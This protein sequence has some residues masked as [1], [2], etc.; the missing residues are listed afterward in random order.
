MPGPT[1]WFGHGS[2]ESP[3]GTD[4]IRP[5]P[6]APTKTEFVGTLEF[7]FG[8]LEYLKGTGDSK[9]VAFGI[10][11]KWFDTK[12]EA[13]AHLPELLDQR[14]PRWDDRE[15]II[16]LRSP[17]DSIPSTEQD[18][19]YYLGDLTID[20]EDG[21]TIASRWAKLWLPAADDGSGSSGDGGAGSGNQQRFLLEAPSDTQSG[22]AS[23]GQAPT[24]T[25]GALKALIAELSGDGSKEYDRCVQLTYEFKRRDRDHYIPKGRD[26]YP[27]YPDHDFSSGLAAKSVVHK[28]AR[29]RG[30]PPNTREELWLDGG[31]SALFEVEFGPPTL[32]DSS[33]DGVNDITMYDRS[34]VSARPLPA[35][36]YK[37]H[38]NNRLWFFLVCDGYVQR[39]EW[40]VTV[41]APAG[42]LH[43][44]F[45]DPVT[46]G[47]AVLAD[48]TNGVL[49][50]TS[51]TDANS[52]SATIQRI[53]W[54][55]NAGSTDGAGTVTLTLSPHTGL[56]NHVLDFIA[57][58]SKVTLSLDVDEATVDIA[59][60]TL[61][62]P[63]TNQPW[64]S[65][66]KLM[67]RIHNDPV[68]PV[69]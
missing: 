51:F 12:E 58:D 1:R 57:L 48:G 38:F 23:Q 45:F 14:D 5:H 31:D 26:R 10:S 69:P 25:L 13:K 47:S 56:A 59:S 21:Y 20:G 29:G 52:T 64:K 17:V 53:A 50:P 6:D 33:G 18:G 42:T 3:T 37:F 67:L 27:R 9:V 61:S 46:V 40:T 49:E 35:G 39:Y 15:A 19:R 63:V 24:I 2:A 32:Y 8:V 4:T 68:T 55:P 44:A 28:D 54:K 16:F 62:W 43:E 22:A 11:G 30:I 66:D 36:E 65:G 60:N 7:K 41:T 34:V